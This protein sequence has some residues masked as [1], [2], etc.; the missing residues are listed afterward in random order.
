MASP[1]IRSARVT[2]PVRWAVTL[3]TILGLVIGTAAPVSAASVPVAA[4]APAAAGLAAGPVK[5]SLV[6]WNAGNII[7]DAVFTNEATMTESQIQSFFNS[8]VSTCRGGSD[9]YGPIICLKDFRIDSVSM[10]ADKYCKGY[11]GAR[12]ESAARI[13]YRVSQACDINPQVL[14][15]MLQK[16]QGLVTHTWP[17]KWR[18]DIALGQGCPDTAPCDPKFVGFF[19]Q[20]YGAARQ[21][22]LYMEGRYFT[23]YAPGKTWNIQYNPNKSCGSSPVRVENKATSALYY[24]TPY[25]P[26]AAA[27]KAGYGTGDSCSAYGNRNF[28][29]YFTDWF[30][31]AK[32]AVPGAPSGIRASAGDRQATVSWAA[33]GATGGAPITAYTV[34]AQPGGKTVSTTGATTATMTG[35]ANGTA[36]KF[37]VRA[38]NI[39]GTS[40]ASSASAAVTPQSP[41]LTR[42]GG[43]SRY[44]TAVAV[45]KAAFPTAGVPVAYVA[46]GQDFPDALAGAAAAGV[47]GGPVLLT[48]PDA[49]PAEVVAELKR[50]APQ[51]VVIL[52]EAGVVSTAVEQQVRAIAASVTRQGG[53]SRYE[54]AVAVSKAAFP[55]A[56]VPVAYVS[57]GRDFPD[58]LAGAAAAGA[59]G[60]PVLLTRPDALP[61]EVVAELKR[62]APQRVVI[63][64]EAGVVSTAVERQLSA[65]M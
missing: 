36:Y 33:P 53:A 20:I 40:A 23:W 6:G 29:N 22:Q 51:R 47:L 60:G 42:Q 30:G 46:N 54:T 58:A 12:N 15:V 27:M 5:T 26:N 32:A 21:M 31:P 13:I 17:S 50:L 25:Q 57:S 18:Y 4:P 38:T 9:Q 64:G 1:G 43:A 37:T 19:H 55:T 35:L 52:G 49:L 7:S 62:L 8:K 10:P 65:L 2:L 34:T 16:E 39:A 3:L 14:I 44:E 41:A 56:G 45:S 59:L 24:Y 28:Y 11:T 61:A 63:L 48:R